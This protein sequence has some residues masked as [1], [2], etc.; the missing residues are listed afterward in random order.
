MMVACHPLDRIQKLVTD[1]LGPEH[2]LESERRRPSARRAPFGLVH[3][4]DL[5]R[6]A[7]EAPARPARTKGARRVEE[8][9]QDATAG[10]AWMRAEEPFGRV[11]PCDRLT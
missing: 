5:L 2:V 4:P 6:P 3:L 7:M 8:G 1:A 11:A 9:P 10:L